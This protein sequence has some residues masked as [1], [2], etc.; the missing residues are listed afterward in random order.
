MKASRRGFPRAYW[1]RPEQ[2]ESDLFRSPEVAALNPA[3]HPS[4]AKLFE[5]LNAVPLRD[6]SDALDFGDY[7]LL[8]FRDGSSLEELAPSNGNILV[9][10]KSFQ[11]GEIQARNTGGEPVFLWGGRIFTGGSQN[12]MLRE[13]MVVPPG[14]T[15]SLPVYCV[16]QGRWDE[17]KGVFAG[18]SELPD[19]LRYHAV[20]REPLTETAQQSQDAL[21][22]DIQ[23]SL[24]LL[25]KMNET[26]NIDAGD[27]AGAPDF[28]NVAVNGR[29][30]TYVLDHYLGL[31]SL[32]LLPNEKFMGKAMDSMARE[33]AWRKRMSTHARG[34]REYFRVYDEEKKVAI[35]CLPDGR[36]LKD[37]QGDFI[38]FNYDELDESRSFRPPLEKPPPPEPPADVSPGT[39]GGRRAPESFEAFRELLA[40][41][42]LVPV[43]QGGDLAQFAIRHPRAPVMGRAVFY[44]QQPA[45]VEAFVSG[46]SPGEST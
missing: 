23:S 3:E 5:Q 11:V 28:S 20:A 17:Q 40:G 39:G 37:L 29:R 35:R 2:R 19:L 43:A 46:E 34:A 22:N 24:V 9:K 32:K 16:E 6:T 1:R 14:Q 8:G 31:A 10:E 38:L 30:G 41:S 27:S 44:K 4:A 21:W 33:I 36:P 25:D 15:A 13:A 12:R 42:V 45:F 26:M 7:G 18:E